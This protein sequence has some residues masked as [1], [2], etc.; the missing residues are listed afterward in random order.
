MPRMIVPQYLVP[1]SVL[2]SEPVEVTRA[3]KIKTEGKGDNKRPK[4]SDYFPGCTAYRMA[5]EVVRGMKRKT[6]FNG[7][8]AE[9][10]VLDEVSVTV[11]AESEPSVQ[12][13]EYVRLAGVMVGAVTEENSS[14]AATYVQ[15][16]GVAAVKREGDK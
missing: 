2:A 12:V 9:V 7:R 15:A 3:P 14:D 11:W 13:G 5:V 1:A 10:P 8:S 16:L 4:T 6:L